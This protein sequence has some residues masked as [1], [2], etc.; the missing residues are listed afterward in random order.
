MLSLAND[1]SHAPLIPCPIPHLLARSRPSAW[2]TGCSPKCSPKGCSPKRSPKR[3]PKG[4][5]PHNR[6]VRAKKLTNMPIMRAARPAGG[7][8]CGLAKVWAARPAGG[9]TRAGWR[10]CELR[11]RRGACGLAKV[12]A[13]HQQLAAGPAVGGSTSPGTRRR[14]RQPAC[15][16]SGSSWTTIPGSWSRGR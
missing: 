6:H 12:P 10:R 2:P 15:P 7:D 8:A 13:L 4:C 5:S 3:S 11:G 16:R 9:G 14:L 1:R